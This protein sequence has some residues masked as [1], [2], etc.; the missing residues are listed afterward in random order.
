VNAYRSR[1]ELFE[2][3]RSGSPS[4]LV[5][6]LDRTNLSVAKLKTADD[7]SGSSA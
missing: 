6:D 4:T 5:A 1:A 3:G 7:L 2:C